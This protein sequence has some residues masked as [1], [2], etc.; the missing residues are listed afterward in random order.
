MFR[1]LNIGVT[2][3]GTLGSGI[4]T[5]KYNKKNIANGNRAE[6]LGKVNA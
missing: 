4:L 6:L 5:G 2:A 3:W 1:Y